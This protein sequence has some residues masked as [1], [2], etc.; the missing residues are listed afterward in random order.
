MCSLV[1]KAT[2]AGWAAFYAARRYGFTPWYGFVVALLFQWSGVLAIWGLETTGDS[3]VWFPLLVLAT[4]RLILGQFRSWPGV[5]LVTFLM[6]VCGGYGFLL[7]SSVIMAL[8]YVWAS[9]SRAKN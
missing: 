4:D 9:D 2:V 6:L 5:A 7:A 3:L 8:G 1:A